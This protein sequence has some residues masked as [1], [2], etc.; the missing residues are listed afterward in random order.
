MSESDATHTNEW[1]DRPGTQPRTQKERSPG[2][3]VGEKVTCGLG[4]GR[5]KDARSMAPGLDLEDM[6]ST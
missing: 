6:I 1:A 5:G 3:E 2:E 4:E